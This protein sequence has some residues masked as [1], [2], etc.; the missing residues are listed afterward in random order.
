MKPHDEAEV[1]AGEENASDTGRNER[2][3]NERE[4]AGHGGGRE[5]CEAA[6]WR[7]VCDGE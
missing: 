7:G 3:E 5:G 4:R 1:E 6:M 2:M